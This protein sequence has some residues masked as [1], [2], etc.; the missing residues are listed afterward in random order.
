VREAVGR[1]LADAGRPQAHP[2]GGTG[3]NGGPPSADVVARLARDAKRPLLVLLDAPE[4]MPLGL[5]RELRRWTA[6]TVS[7]LRASGAR[8]VIACGPEH[9]EQAGEFFPATM[10]YEGADGPDAAEGAVLPPCVRIGDLPAEQAARARER[11]GL[12]DGSLA[13]GDARHPLA[14]RMLAEIR[15]ALNTA[16]CGS[17]APSRTEIFSAHLDLVA[18][19]IA[20]RVAAQLGRAARDGAVRRLAVRAAGALHEAARRC[21]GPGQGAVGRADFEEVF[22]RRSGWRSAVLEEGVL[23][24]AGDQFRFVDEEFA[25]WLQGRHLEVEAALAA[26][27]HER[28]GQSAE[29]EA[30]AAY[31]RSCA[32]AGPH[33]PRHRVGP[34]V[35]ALL[36]CDRLEG[37]AVLER[38]L[39]PLIDVCFGGVAPES[40]WWAT[41]LLKDTLR[42]VNDARPYD[43]VL[44]R[45]A[46][47]IAADGHGGDFGPGFWRRLR[48]PTGQ[49]TELLRLMLPADPLHRPEGG[50][51][52]GRCLDVVDEL[53]AADPEAVLPLLC[54]WF[55]DRRTLN[56]GTPASGLPQPTVASAAQALLYAH[57]GRA[58]GLLLDL[59]IDACHPRA[60]ELLGELAQDEPAALCRAVERW[61]HDERSLRRIA[62]AEYGTQM[63]RHARTDAEREHLAGA[64]RALLRRSGELSLHASAMALLL[65]ISA[66]RDQ[67]LDAALDLLGATGARELS[68]ALTR[69]LRERPEPVLAAFRARLG[70]PGS[71]AHHLVETLAEATDAGLAVA[72]AELVREYAE[73]RPER[74][75]EALAPFVRRRLTPGA[76]DRAGLQLLTDALLSSPCAP[77][78]ASLVRALG[79][80]GPGPLRDELLDVLLLGE[81]E[82]TVLDAA[83]AAVVR[84]GRVHAVEDGNGPAERPGRGF[85]AELV[86]RIGL[87]MAR[88]PEGAACFDR[89]LVELSREVP[90]FAELLRAWAEA[91]PNAWAAVVGPSARRMCDALADRA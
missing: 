48:L 43:G 52:N 20:G 24:E 46:Q 22:P 7:W 40:V 78:R 12:D 47:R 25:D 15:G 61:A 14:M 87:L 77:L 55:T 85:T 1:A 45:L 68:D 74:A 84:G 51:G 66:D 69:A 44:T 39:L 26:L 6:G 2:D 34:V 65:R 37:P 91:A 19:R 73:L 76:E 21:L 17:A 75:A 30:S 59:L 41:R 54:G 42:R 27:V 18:L 10:L 28:A 83:L 63:A 72:T 81:R 36:L 86:R 71:G 31:G 23:E 29:L 8:M 50:R 5:A 89:R 88:T 70:E 49:Q 32:P 67:H 4:E 56:G 3:A 82:I 33:V 11:Y 64:A 58:P 9:W 60:D 13:E 35:Q 90:G 16:D 80:A 53:A 62:A 57:R 79:E 38:H